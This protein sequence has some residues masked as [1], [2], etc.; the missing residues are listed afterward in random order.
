MPSRKL[1]HIFLICCHRSDQNILPI[2]SSQL[3][4]IIAQAGSRK[5]HAIGAL[6]TEH[7]DT[8]TDVRKHLLEVSS[9]NEALLEKLESSVFL[10]C[11]DDTAPVTRD[12]VSTAGWYGD[13]R[14]RYFDK[15]LQYVVFENGKAGV[16]IEVGGRTAKAELLR[17]N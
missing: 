12:E 2:L 17:L 10:L 13:G 6:T 14:N 11:L 5:A 7:R 3:N 1:I 8:W 4:R 9:E 15:S 16:I